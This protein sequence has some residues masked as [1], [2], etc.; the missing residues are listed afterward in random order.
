[1]IVWL[2]VEPTFNT[3]DWVQKT[4]QNSKAID[5][6]QRNYHWGWCV[7]WNFMCHYAELQLERGAVIAAGA[8]VNKIDTYIWSVGRSSR[9]VL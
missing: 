9:H 3:T 8:V 5:D 2:L 6:N 4:R 1:M 7:D